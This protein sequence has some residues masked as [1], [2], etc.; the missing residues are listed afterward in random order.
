MK[1]IQEQQ[2][3]KLYG[4]I[5]V[6]TNKITNK[7]YI[8]QHVSHTFNPSYKGS[9]TVF[10]KAL[11]KYGK[12]NFKTE[13]LETIFT[14][15]V[16]LNEREQYWIKKFN[17]TDS[18]VGYN[19]DLGGTGKGKCSE[20]TKIKI[21]ASEVGKTV[22]ECTKKRMKDVWRNRPLDYGKKIVKNLGC[23][24]LSKK[25]TK[26]TANMMSKIA[27]ARYNNIASEDR[28]EVAKKIIATRKQKFKDWGSFIKSRAI[29]WGEEQK[30]EFSQKQK[31]RRWYTDGKSCVFVPYGSEPAGFLPGR[32]ITK[33][34][35]IV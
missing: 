13:L 23:G 24:M 4:Y 33:T 15:Q 5:Y 25:H 29:K 14:N 1:S 32:I 19:L 9:G 27:L 17:S 21:S 34:R 6:T 22:S 12:H 11:K 20:Q 18:V 8:G 10:K 16:D 30:K 35:G 7:V 26:K 3:G 31:N 28:K 2:S